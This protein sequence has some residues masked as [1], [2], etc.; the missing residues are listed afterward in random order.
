M[1]DEVII[2]KNPQLT[3]DQD[4]EYLRSE[5]LKYIE[6]L[7]S[8]LWT[9]YNVHDP[10]ITILEAL[11]YA[12]T[13]LGYRSS[14]PMQDLL[15][16]DDGK[17]PDSQ[18]LYTAK[19]I[20]TQAPLNRDDYR[21]LL[22]DIEGVH[23][24]WIFTDETCSQA[25]KGSTSIIEV[26]I[27]ADCKNSLIT[28]EHSTPHQVILSG[29]YKVLLDLDDDP[30]LGDLNNGEVQVLSP[31]NSLPAGAAS[32]T[33]IFP[34]WNEADP[35]LFNLDSDSINIAKKPLVT[36]LSSNKW[37]AK[38]TINYN[39]KINVIITVDLQ[40]EERDL[41][42]DDINSFLMKDGPF[43]K[44]VFTL[45]LSKISAAKKIIQTVTRVLH[46]NRNLCEDFVK[47]TNIEDEEIAICCDI[48][49]SPDSDMEQ[50]QAEV[51]FRIE[52][53]FNPSVRFYLLKEMI[54]KGYTT[55]EI[56]EGPRLKH[57]FIDTD[58]LE[59]TG[60]RAEIHTSDIIN[61]IMDI[62]GVLAVRNFKMT[63]YDSNG[64]PVP[65]ETGQNWCITVTP[66]HK[67]VLSETK[68]KIIFYKNQFPYLP[69]LPEVGDTIDWLKASNAKNKLTGHVDDLKIPEGQYSPLG[70]YTAVETLF[71]QTYGIGQAGLPSN[72][73]DERKAQALQLKAYLL[74]YDQ[75]L[76][77]FFSQLK[78]ASQLFSTDDKIVQTYYGQFLDN[79]KDSDALYRKTGTTNLLRELLN[80]QDSTTTSPPN[81]WEKLYEPN[82]TFIDRRNRFLD[83]LM[84]RFAES[85]N[86]YVFLMYT[87]DFQQQ[88]EEGID[89]LD[90]IKNKIDFLKDYPDMSYERACAFNYF[91][92]HDDFT[93]DT[94]QFW[95]T[96]NV[97]GLE[98][99]ICRLGGFRDPSDTIKSY[100]RRFLYCLGSASIIT[101]NDTPPKFQFVFKNKNG[102]ELTSVKKYDTEDLMEKDLV[103]C[104]THIAEENYFRV[105]QSGTKWY[106]S[107]IDNES[108][109]LAISND[110]D[111]KEDV[112]ISIKLFGEEFI[113]ECDFEGL[114]LIEHILLRPRNQDFN[115]APV[116]LD[117][118]CNFCGE[119]DPYSFRMTVVLPYWPEHIHSMAFRKYFEEMIRSEA[120]AHTMVRICWINDESLYDF[121][122]AYSQWIIELA[123]YTLDP[124]D[125]QTIDQFKKAN[126]YLISLLF[127]LH[128]EYPLATLY[129]CS[130][131][132]DTNP[133]MLGKTSLG[134]FK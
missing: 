118:D 61:F 35:E 49:V 102:D 51:F 6:E 115:L 94:S 113:R 46:E 84:S 79:I 41:T 27:Y 63:K 71:P 110:F 109:I 50:V 64:D 48:D 52:E 18:T 76:A 21:K 29:L 4:Y 125:P 22:I 62:D 20:F 129:N 39:I 100:Y 15:T 14:F 45:Y 127:N 121:E 74:F 30:V 5:G 104:H 69:S 88:K 31:A 17:I 133:V 119:Q 60:L 34:M 38:I 24:A 68:S 95:N 97:A 44:K 130:E 111:T 89:P 70:N 107:I 123:N 86:D 83:H 7:G 131:S 103:V 12:I 25:T 54:E 72:A 105:E 40:P 128:S 106:F 67:P 92:L 37:N 99:K 33:I 134:T 75:L 87:L 93:L 117:P 90:L 81:D 85:F 8:K 10:G 101:T 43:I 47:I 65:G 126:D 120:P 124:L 66:C 58:E 112:C 16:N 1:D 53:Y 108:N 56:F 3:P 2:Q 57:G 26:P 82:E 96:D 122:K 114:H 78:N 132:E 55:D 98:K 36:A 73:T 9:D 32:L 59:R 13:E 77:D 80:I 11:C 42:I 23:N 116:C 19:T 91:P 28:S